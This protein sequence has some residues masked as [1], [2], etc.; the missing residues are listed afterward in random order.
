MIM[1]SEN[2]TQ[3]EK[4]LK[5]N[6]ASENIAHELALPRLREE[7]TA[8]EGAIKIFEKF[9]ENDYRKVIVITLIFYS[10][11]IA[12]AANGIYIV[13]EKFYNQDYAYGN[14]FMPYILFAIFIGTHFLRNQILKSYERSD[15]YYTM[16][17]NSLQNDISSLESEFRKR[18]LLRILTRFTSFKR[19]SYIDL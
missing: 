15:A 14:S 11:G 17:I 12:L 4:L 7:I 1:S 8:K 13:V 3:S 6:E 5:L 19:L 18:R 2:D 16:L 9:D 10:T